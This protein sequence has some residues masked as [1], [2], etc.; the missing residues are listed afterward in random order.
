MRFKFNK[1][2]IKKK[3]KKEKEEGKERRKKACFYVKCK[4]EKVT[5]NR[6][7]TDRKKKARKVIQK[8]THKQKPRY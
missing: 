5:K 2:K 6:R 1:T 8:H 4:N 7:Q 3:E